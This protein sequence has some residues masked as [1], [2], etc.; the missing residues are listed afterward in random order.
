MKFNSRIFSLSLL[1]G[2]LAWILDAAVEAFLFQSGSFGDLVIMDVAPAD[3]TRR[4]MVLGLFLIF[5]FI[6]A[7]I[8]FRRELAEQTAARRALEESREWFRGLAELLPEPVFEADLTARL[9]YVN[10]RA[11]E[12]FGYTREDFEAGLSGLDM[13]AP[14]SREDALRSLQ[15]RLEGTEPGV[16]EYTALRRDGTTFPVLFHAS[17]FRVEGR[18]AGIRGIIVDITKQKQAEDEKRETERRFRNIVESSPMGVFLYQLK[19]DGRLVF[20]AANPAADKI[21]GVDNSKFIGK[22]IEEAFPPLADTEVPARYREAAANGTPWHTLQIDYDHGGITGAYEV[23]AFQ[24]APNEVA[25]MFLDITERKRAEEAVRASEERLRLAAQS[26][27][28]GVWEYDIAEDRLEW[29]DLMFELHGCPRFAPEEGIQR[30]RDCVHPEDRERAEGEFMASLAPGG[31]P[32]DTE[33]RIVRK[34]DGE[35]RY[36]RGLAG[37]TRD[38]AGEAIRTVGTNWDI[39][40]SKRTEAALRGS[41]ERFRSVIEQLNDATYIL[42][43]GRFDLVNPRFCELTGVTPAEAAGPDF[44]FW[45][46]VAPDSVPVIRKRLEKRERG[47]E[48]PGI[49]EFDV[50]HKDGHTIQVE[51]SVT[52]IDYQGGKAILGL[53]RDITEQKVLKQQLLLAQKMESIGRL[54]GGVAHDLNNLLT[55]IM[56]YGDLILGELAAEDDR[57]HD[58][59][60]ILDAAIRARDLVRQLLAFGRQ[61]PMEFE[62]IDL[63]EMVEGFQRLLK[64]TIREDVEIRFLPSPASPTIRGDRGQLEQVIMNLVVN[65]QDAMPLGGV[66]T[67]ETDEVELDWEH[68]Q[69]HPGVGPGHYAVLSVTDTGEG[70]DAETRDKIFEPFFSTKERGKGTGLGLATVYGII[71]QHDGH[72]GVYSEPGHGASF[73]CY[74]PLAD[75]SAV[76][77]VASKDEADGMG[78]TETIMLVEDEPAVRSLAVRVLRRQGYTV[79]EADDPEKCLDLLE[80]FSDPLHLLV[81]DV[82]LPGMDGKELYGKVQAL[83]PN[84]KVLYMSGYSADIITHRGIVEDGVPFLQKPFTVQGFSARVREVLETV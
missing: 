23:S 68:A 5:G 38:E 19:S 47:E 2:V 6:V 50:Q 57:R 16:M 13:L 49:Y 58:V 26:G 52:E 51:A 75:E 20:A 44:D 43:N 67:I 12:L 73:R 17:L 76:E 66:L 80:G 28:V 78:G 34:D 4:V 35:T 41:E 69:A 55:P 84:S 82:I 53:L 45:D 74:L 71:R 15:E 22:T 33:F 40:E 54:S 64:R 24:T 10:Q 9:T 42:F 46:L 1:L 56:G 72:I 32:F 8:L 11:F 60:E 48:V 61:Q 7:N 65:G 27:R 30:W 63:N 37:I 18:P 39:T 25:V 70:M 14:E 59:K 77:L 79:M 83:F 21:L 81:T 3:L 62:A 29:D 36:I 31:P